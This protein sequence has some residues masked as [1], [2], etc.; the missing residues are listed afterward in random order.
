MQKDIFLFAVGVL[1]ALAASGC[2]QESWDLVS[3]PPDSDSI[4]VRLVNCSRGGSYQLLLEAGDERVQTG[5]VMPMTTSPLLKSPADSAF[6]RLLDATG[7]TVKD[8]YTRT[9]FV[10]RTFE[11]MVLLPS[12]IGAPHA[13]DADTLIRLVTNPV[14]LPP[15]GRAQVRFLC[16]VP[17][18]TLAYEV[19]LGCPSGEYFDRQSFRASGA[20]R[21]LPAGELVLSILHGARPVAIVRGMLNERRFA[22]IIVAGS[23]DQVRVFLL[24]ELDPS[25]NALRPMMPV[26]E[27]ERTA[28]LRWMNVSR[29][30]FDSITIA[31]VG[32]VAR[33]GQ[34]QYLSEYHVI[35]A[36]TGALSDTVR[37]YSNGILQDELPI[38]IEVGFRYTVIVLDAP[39]FGAPASRLAVVSRDP[40][41]IPRDSTEWRVLNAMG[42]GQAL[43]V[44]LGAR[45]D[46]AGKYHNGEFL[47]RALPDAS[48][49]DRVRLPAGDVPFIVRGDVPERIVAVAFDTA[50]AGRQYTL[51]VFTSLEGKTKLYTVADDEQS[52]AVAPVDDGVYVQVIN[53]FADKALLQCRFEGGVLRDGVSVGNAVATVLPQGERALIVNGTRIQ[54]TLDPAHVVTVIAAGRSS[55]PQMI[56][57]DSVSL[58]PTTF[59]A[60]VRCV[61]AAP[62][63]AMLRM[64]RDQLTS[65]DQW[66]SNIFADR[67]AFGFVSRPVTL[68]RLQRINLVFGTSDSPPRELLR[69]DGSVSFGLGRA[70]TVVFYGTQ[71][72][73]YNYFIFQEP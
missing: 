31:S 43:T 5:L 19:R 68:D 29:Y 18:T 70:Y 48:L 7:T 6:V 42:R 47:A 46:A 4:M 71:Q 69:P 27:V 53:A 36:C 30:P 72:G 56:V 52:G 22:T 1:V 11:T 15:A 50:R 35:P 58:Q 41:A 14:P 23:P 65:L 32:T 26:P 59:I 21:E 9:R 62:D 60:R 73:G 51:I 25:I 13:Q 67:V 17:D 24:D 2:E 33:R 8:Q 3:P 38:S 61:N 44:F 45:L 40:R 34:G 20:P 49:S 54:L 16:A 28:E 63:V 37:L 39:N 57:L 66:D 12:P 64:S 55:A 10:K